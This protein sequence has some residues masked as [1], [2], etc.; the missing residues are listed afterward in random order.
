MMDDGIAAF[1][2]AKKTSGFKAPGE[3]YLSPKIL[4]LYQDATP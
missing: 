3:Q 2:L 1:K 4:K